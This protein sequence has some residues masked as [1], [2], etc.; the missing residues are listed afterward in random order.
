MTDVVNK[1]ITKW[2]QSIKN[3]SVHWAGW[4]DASINFIDQLD[5]MTSHAGPTRLYDALPG[6]ISFPAPGR[7]LFLVAK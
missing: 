4:P 2:D 3:W 1:A 7:R 5:I 6:L